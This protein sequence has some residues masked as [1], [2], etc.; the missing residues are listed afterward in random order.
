MKKITLL[1]MLFVGLSAFS[2][3]RRYRIMF[4]D[5][6]SSTMMIGWEQISGTNATV[7][8]GTTDHGTTWSN[9][10]NSKTVDR[11]V[12]DKGMNNQFA[13]LSGLTPN[14][15]YYFVIKD[16]EG[17]SSRYWFRTAPNTNDTMSFI[18]G[19]DSRNNRTPRQNANKMVAK[20]KPTAIFFGGDMTN[21]DTD[22]EWQ[23]WFDDW[24]LTIA[25]DG[26]MFPIIP[27][28]GN[29]EYNNSRIYNLFNCPNSD[30]YYNITFGANLYSLYTLNS[31]ITAGGIQGA[32]LASQ[33]QND[34]AIWKS[35]QYHKPMRPHVSNKSEGTD[36]YNNWA[37]LF[38]DQDVKLVYESDSHTVKTTWPIKPCASGTNCEEGFERDDNFGT[39]YVGEGCWGAPLRASD[40]EKSWSRDFGSFNQFK[41]VCVSTNKIEVKTIAIDNADS[42]SENGNNDG[43]A[44]PA[45]VNVWNP[46]N[47]AIV[48]I[49]NSAL[50]APVVNITSQ[51]NNEYLADG[52]NVIVSANANDADGTI[53]YVEF[54][55]G[56]VLQAADATA[57]YQINYSF[58]NGEHDIQTIAY[59]NDNLSN[60][61]TIKIYVGTY[62][63]TIDQTVDNDV[64]Q[65]ESDGSVYNDSSDLELV[66]D[67]YDSQGYQK[68]GLRFNTLN[69]PNGAQIT[70]A[71]IQ[72]K[73][74]STHSSTVDLQV[75]VENSTNTVDYES[76]TTTNVTGTG[77]TYYQAI[78]WSVPAWNTDEALAAQRTP[79]LATTIQNIVSQ[80]SW[81]PGNA[82]GIKIE[83]TGATLSG[84]GSNI[85]RAYS[86][87]NSDASR[88]PVLHIEYTMDPSTLSTEKI[89][90]VDI[91]KV[92]PNPFKD[93]VTF[94]N[95]TESFKNGMVTV[96]TLTGKVAYKKPLKGKTVNL[97]FLAKG[98]Y[99]ITLEG[100]NSK[101]ITKKIIK[102]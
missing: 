43:C 70:N 45:G 9:Y 74:K 75:F 71:Y 57:P 24:Q 13:K 83:G 41:W 87:N 21:G 3:T 95:L 15:N 47:G 64:E 55:I 78:N 35:A 97:N 66:Y 36:E 80:T 40:D 84:A 99:I 63:A 32:W 62:S 48:T 94:S 23:D 51:N 92:Y 30:A 31:E 7:Y 79:N 50:Q 20:L 98:V 56:G 89:K 59:D 68:I 46:S 52:N 6:P 22:G 90:D 53:S 60:S 42:V 12:T 100:A 102:Q 18:S 44:L 49:L 81:N 61:E 54:Y 88:H 38:F 72:F 27:A 93:V 26:R 58:A 17:T 5:N 29:H 39:V 82:M 28:R 85:R 25:A 37:Q 65:K 101:I 34:N 77:R 1:L 67:S 33:L 69:I 4:T 8:Y 11:T 76:N 14:T 2:N 86:L 91:L 96:Y 73:A 16:S 19:G 10:S